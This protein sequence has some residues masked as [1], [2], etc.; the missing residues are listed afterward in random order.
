MLIYM[1]KYLITQ[2]HFLDKGFFHSFTPDYASRVSPSQLLGTGLILALIIVEK[3]VSLNFV[4]V[5]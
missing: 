2:I 1:P 4:D 3:Q 5:I